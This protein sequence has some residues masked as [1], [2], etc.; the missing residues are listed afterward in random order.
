[1]AP[2]SDDETGVQLI[3]IEHIPARAPRLPERRAEA[4]HIVRCSTCEIGR[5]LSTD[6]YFAKQQQQ[7]RRMYLH[8][9][10]LE[11]K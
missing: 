9:A 5:M 11:I 8:L 7:K 10:M 1:M 6:I 2:V 3:Q 4:G